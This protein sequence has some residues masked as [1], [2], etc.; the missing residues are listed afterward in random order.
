MQ[1]YRSEQDAYAIPDSYSPMTKLYN[2]NSH[3]DENP[4]SGTYG[5]KAG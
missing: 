1:V 2:R 3:L 4:D 5:Y